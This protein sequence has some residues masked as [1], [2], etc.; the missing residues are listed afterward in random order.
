MPFFDIDDRRVF[1]RHWDTNTP[2]VAAL[3]FLHGFGEHSGLYHRYAAELADHG[4]QLWAIDE[5]G[6]GLSTGERGDVGSYDTVVAAGV[7]LSE[8]AAAA[9]PQLPQVI[10]GHSL[11]SLGALLVALDNPGRFAAAVISGTPLSRLGWLTDVAAGDAPAGSFEL[12]LD[13]LSADRFYR[14]E[15][16]NDPLAFTSADVVGLLARTFPPAWDRL[17]RDLPALQIPILAVHG[18]D[19]TIAPIAGVQEWQERLPQL[20]IEKIDGAA[21]DILNEV[22]HARVAD[23]VG[24]FVAAAATTS[25]ATS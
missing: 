19:D 25:V 1:Y 21:H 17:E 13:D 11:G 3:I 8:I 24:A 6:H 2:A 4:V 9:A 7:R 18:A 14:D 15:L 5:P 12:E 16:E 23:L 10:A 20:R 22:Q